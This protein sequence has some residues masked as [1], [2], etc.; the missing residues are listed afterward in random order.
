MS[1]ETLWLWGMAGSAWNAP[2]AGSR[3]A[4]LEKH[5]RCKAVCKLD[6][7][8]VEK[9]MKPITIYMVRHGEIA[10]DGRRRFIGQIDLPLS[11]TGR[12]Q[13][14]CLRDALS[15]IEFNGVF[16]SDLDRSV[17]TAQIICEK[18]HPEPVA[19]KD[20][21]EISL[22]SWEGM[23]FD[24]VCRHHPDDFK[25]RGADIVN[26]QPPGGESFARCAE[27][28]LSALDD[29]VNR[30]AGNILMVGHAGVNRIILSRALGM[31]LENLFRITQDYA[32][33]NVLAA[34]TSGYRIVALNHTLGM[35]Y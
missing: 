10:A 26:Y 6:S 19:R 13:A 27:R 3:P 2:P 33:L 28:V 22:G 5:S 25:K 31:P 4:P 9:L 16:C 21:R 23:S 24:E 35:F 20:L 14:A 1:A 7:K 29:I 30:F 32:C 18:R 11:E 34:G 15:G 17:C 12:K 8:L